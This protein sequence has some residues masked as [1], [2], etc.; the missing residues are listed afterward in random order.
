MCKGM[1]K[2]F[3]E[4]IRGG[5]IIIKVNVLGIRIGCFI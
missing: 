5:G 2:E 3:E 4:I 1:F